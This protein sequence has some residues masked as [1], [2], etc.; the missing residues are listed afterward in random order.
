MWEKPVW[1]ACFRFDIHVH[2]NLGTCLLTYG[3]MVYIYIVMLF[4]L[5]YMTVL[6]VLRAL[7]WHLVRFETLF[8]WLWKSSS[9]SGRRQIAQA[10]TLN[11][12]GWQT[13]ARI[14]QHCMFP[15][16]LFKLHEWHGWSTDDRSISNMWPWSNNNNNITITQAHAHTCTC[17]HTHIHICTI[18]HAHTH[19]HTDSS[20]Y[21]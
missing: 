5:K 6:I 1:F 13:R 7:K 11:T 2:L 17:T 3:C 19:K 16:Y 18:A 9:F 12:S 14:V 4:T 21:T 15:C 10:Q 20:T 8:F